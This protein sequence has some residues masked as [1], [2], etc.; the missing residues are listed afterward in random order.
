MSAYRVQTCPRVP[1]NANGRIPLGTV[2]DDVWNVGQRLHVVDHRGT[3]VEA[4]DRRKRGLKPGMA[5]LA[6]KRFEQGCLLSAD[7]GARA[8]VEYQVEIIPGTQN[9]LSEIPL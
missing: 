6:F 1:F 7:V 2:V 5:A 3:S 4:N 8:P 9:I